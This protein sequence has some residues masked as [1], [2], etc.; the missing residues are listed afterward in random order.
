MHRGKA[1]FPVRF[2]RPTTACV[3]DRSG[4]HPP[5]NPVASASTLTIGEDMYPDGMTEDIRTALASLEGVGF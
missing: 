4:A 5:P 2:W 1:G 3:T